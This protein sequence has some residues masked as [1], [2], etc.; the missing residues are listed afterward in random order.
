MVFRVHLALGARARHQQLNALYVL[1]KKTRPLPGGGDFNML[2]GE[3][4]SDLFLAA[5]G[6]QNAN[7]AVL[8]TFPSDK[9]QQHLDFVPHSREIRVRKFQVPRVT[10]S[11]HLPLVV[12]FEG[13]VEEER[14]RAPRE[15]ICQGPEYD[16]LAGTKAVSQS[17]LRKAAAWRRSGCGRRAGTWPRSTTVRSSPWGYPSRPGTIR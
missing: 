16:S 12:D 13:E 9:P 15:P 6:L 11:D 3:R 2:W 10:Y 14:R 7:T 1:V 17:A 4:E 5:T 8:P